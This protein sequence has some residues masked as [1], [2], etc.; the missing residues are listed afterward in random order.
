MA[1]EIERYGGSSNYAPGILRAGRRPL[2]QFP[3]EMLQGTLAN[4]GALGVVL[5][6]RVSGRIVAYALG[7]ALEDHDE[8]G[9]SSDPR[10]GE[11]DTFYLQAM[12]TLPSVKNH[13]EVESHLLD[14]LR[15]RALAS[16]YAYL[17]TLIEERFHGTGPAWFRDAQLVQTVPNYLRSGLSFV[18]LHASL[19]GP[20]D[21]E[22]TRPDGE[23]RRTS[24]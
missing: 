1:V 2:L 14:Q 5:R 6:D 17:S 4:P 24:A 11:R 12:A 9:V 15:A 21:G 10:L 7:S 18:Y 8:E 16:G 20:P 23:R 13:L 22:S 3:L 19:N